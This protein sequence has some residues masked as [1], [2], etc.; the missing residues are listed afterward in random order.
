M[1]TATLTAGA[2]PAA[3][4]PKLFPLRQRTGTAHRRLL[5]RAADLSTSDVEGLTPREAVMF[6]AEARWGSST[7]MQCTHCGTLDEHY[8]SAKEL[9][10]KCAGC[11]KRF[12]VTSSTVFADHKLPLTKIL[13][14]ALEWANP[15][16]GKAAVNLRWDNKVSYRTAFT[17]AHK[18]REGLVRGFN[19]GLLCGVQEMDGADING[20][21]YR[22]KRN[23]PSGSSAA[24]KPKIPAHLL[25][26]EV[27]P[28][29]GEIT[30]PPKPPKFDKASKQ[31]EDRRLMLVMRQ[32]G[33]VKGR[34]A[35]ATRISIALRESTKTVVAMATKFASAESK[36]M[37]DEDPAYA[38]FSRLFQAHDTVNHSKEYSKPGGINNN[39]AESFNRRMRRSVE[40]TY[41]SPSN[42]YMTDYACEAAW[43]EDMREPS[44]F[45]RFR[46][47]LKTALGVGL[48]QWWRGYWQGQYRTH[49]LLIEGPQ[50]AKARGKKKGWKA[51][52]P[53]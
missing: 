34:G 12:S 48:S 29:T 26:P 27:D 23:K 30:G 16:A 4:K 33:L 52:P 14:M 43:R 6:M 37:S 11:G 40:G 35:V 42:K 20:K 32:R 13:K 1:T 22:E 47:L 51:K 15:A 41:I 49:E 44:R 31:P 10:W 19:V 45:D 8:W 18:L 7:Y 3:D 2:S 53:K 24:G 25:K 39:Q 36:M 17:L 9:R 50:D 21:R 5:S 46:G 28:L 38:A